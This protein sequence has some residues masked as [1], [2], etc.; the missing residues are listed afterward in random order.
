MRH[1]EVDRLRRPQ[2]DRAR[3]EAELAQRQYMLVRP[4]NRL[5]VDTL[6]RR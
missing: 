6:E 5:V 2:V 1:A 3:E 4:E